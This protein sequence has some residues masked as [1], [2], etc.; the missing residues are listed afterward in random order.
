M[1]RAA[2][3]MD[4]NAPRVSAGGMITA[5]QR[6]LARFGTPN[7]KAIAA[8]E[9]QARGEPAP[10]PRQMSR[11]ERIADAKER[12]AL[13][14][15]LGAEAR[16]DF[17]QRMLTASQ[18]LAADAY[19]KQVMEQVRAANP[20]ASDNEVMTDAFAIAANNGVS[21]RES[22]MGATYEARADNMVA[23]AMSRNASQPWFQDITV[24]PALAANAKRR[25]LTVSERM[26]KLWC[27]RGWMRWA[28][29]PFGQAVPWDASV[30]YETEGPEGQIFKGFL[31]PEQEA[32]LEGVNHLRGGKKP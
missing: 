13:A 12:V 10:P 7:M 3:D 5:G 30:V 32:L 28:P 15:A 4:N 31:T 24:S 2:F 8:A 25:N 9:A 1:V 19:I 20:E 29:D 22:N 16:S 23:D 27:D 11:Q 18:P 14:Q 17:E 26:G 21:L 6:D